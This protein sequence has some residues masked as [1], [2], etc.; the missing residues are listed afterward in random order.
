MKTSY[1]FIVVISLIFLAFCTAVSYTANFRLILIMCRIM[2]CICAAV[3]I[4]GLV[5][6]CISATYIGIGFIAA[7]LI[8]SMISGRW[9]CPNCGRR[10]GPRI[11]FM[12]RCPHCSH[13][14]GTVS[15]EK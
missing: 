8:A 4:T 12:N 14:L 7:I 6:G 13:D 3:I 2:F 10:Y 11:W 15:D 5:S 9:S 1:L